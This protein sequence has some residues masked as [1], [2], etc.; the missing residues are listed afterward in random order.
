MRQLPKEVKEMQGTLEPSRE[1]ISPVELEVWDGERMPAADSKWPPNIQ[2]IWN[3]RCKELF[4]AGYLAKAFLPHLKRYCFALM[5][6][7]QAEENLIDNGF[8][9]ET[10]GTK[11][12]VYRSVA[13]DFTVWEKSIKIMDSI[14]SKFGFTP[15]D[16]QKIPVIE[17]KQET[18]SLLK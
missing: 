9:E 3:K 14:G 6:A 5:A 18:M 11:G 16:I 1:D 4:K 12:Q 8:I 17:K 2:E 13:I 7:E 10:I 15:L